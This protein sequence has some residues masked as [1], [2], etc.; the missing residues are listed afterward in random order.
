MHFC[1]KTWAGTGSITFCNDTCGA[2]FQSNIIEFTPGITPPAPCE[3][4]TVPTAE[5]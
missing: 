5:V 3:I 1:S 2:I 4:V